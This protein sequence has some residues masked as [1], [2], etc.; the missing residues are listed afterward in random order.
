LYKEIS[1]WANVSVL[2]ENLQEHINEYETKYENEFF[3]VIKNFKFPTLSKSFVKDY[4]NLEKGTKYSILTERI[5]NI[6]EEI[7]ENFKKAND[8]PTKFNIKEASKMDELANLY[9]NTIDTYVNLIKYELITN[10]FE[11]LSTKEQLDILYL[12]RYNNF[13]ANSMLVRYEYMFDNNKTDADFSNPLTIGVASNGKTNAYDYAYFVLKLFSFVI[14]IYAVMSACHSIAGEIKDGTMRYLAIRPISRNNMFFGKWFA[15]LIMSLILI[16]FSGVIAV[17]VGGAVYGFSTQT[18]LTIFNGE[19]AITLHPIAMIGIYLASMFLELIVYSIIAMLLS[20]LFKSDL[21]AMTILIVIY[22]LNSLM[23]V[24]VQGANSWLTF[25]PFS[26]ISLYP[27]FG[28]SIYAVE[29]NFFNLM[30]G[31]KVYAGTH[32]ILTASTILLLTIII[33]TIAVKVLKKKKL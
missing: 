17:L 7:E 23:P 20:V 14:I 16:L 21:L 28:S 11:N 12:S 32:I 33:S 5:N 31:A 15:I 30:F 18:I 24:F 19:I 8:D 27:L 22:L 29:N 1:A 4:T 26:H 10:A 13:N 3:E 2:K 25:Y 9:C 6:S